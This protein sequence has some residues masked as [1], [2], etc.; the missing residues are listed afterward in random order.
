[1]NGALRRRPP[2]RL[3]AAFAVT[4]STLLSLTSPSVHAQDWDGSVEVSTGSLEVPVGGAVSY[5]VRLSK[6]PTQ[7]GWWIIL[8][9]DGGMRADGEYE[10]IRWVPSVG[11]EFNQ[12]NWDQWRGITVYGRRTRIEP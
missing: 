7:D 6:P 2:C 9:V 3:L 12:D 10:G 5:H 11:W 4:L 1:M 8:R